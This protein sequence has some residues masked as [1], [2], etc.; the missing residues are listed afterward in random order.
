VTTL[1]P[2]R[3]RPVA[4]AAARQAG[5]PRTWLVLAGLYAAAVA[6]HSWQSLGH[7]TPAVFTDELLFAKLA[8]SF[9]AGDGFVLRGEAFFFPAPVAVVFQ[10][11]AWLLT[12]AQTAYEVAKALNAAV[13]TASVF[14][15]YWLAR[16]LTSRRASLLAAL[17]AVSAPGLLYHSYLMTDAAG[18]AAFSAALAVMTRAL[19]RPSRAWD[20]AVVGASLLAVLTRTQFVV[21]PLAYILA[22]GLVGRATGEGVRRSYRRHCL[23]CGALIAGGMLGALT[24]GVALGSYLGV[25]DLDYPLRDLIRW[26][27]LSAG[28]LPFSLGWL[29]APGALLGVG[30]LLIRPRTRAEAGFAALVGVITPLVVLESALIATGDAERVMER[31]LVYLVPVGFVAFLAYAERGAPGRLLHAGLA[32]ALGVVALLYPLA[33]ESEYRFSFDSPTLS[34][35]GE[36]NERLTDGDAAAIFAGAAVLGSLTVAMLALWRR[37][38]LGIAVAGICVLAVMGVAAYTADRSMTDR[39][40]AAFAAS[41]PDWLDQSGVGES[42]YLALPGA[43]AHAGWNLEAWNRDFGIP[44]RFAGA[45]PDHYRFPRARA[46]A[47][48]VLTVDGGHTPTTTLVVND[49]GSAAQFEGVVSLRPRPGLT[50]WRFAG[51]PRI[52]SL[53][54]GL[55]HDGWASA[56]VRYRVWSRPGGGAYHVRLALPAGRPRRNVVVAVQGGASRTVRL[57]G[58]ESTRITLPAGRSNAPPPLEIRTDLADF[59]GAGGPAPRLVAVRVSELSYAPFR[60]RAA[61]PI[62]QSREPCLRARTQSTPCSSGWSGAARPTFT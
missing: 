62:A 21:L 15:V 23:S 2:E 57:Q 49:Y 37:P 25:V 27:A 40:L 32:L 50:V 10:A 16:Q 38:G 48:G 22:V 56:L 13:M 46:N 36:L 42:D 60:K 6:Y 18:Y 3:P 17:A 24:G 33:T 55:Y 59:T 4:A 52:R 43:Q 5:G 20:A 47:R 61:L 41:P 51:P 53:A 14:P 11:A 29:I 31:Y 44:I 34:A 39:T 12:E 28:I 54:E 30:F 1:T 8:Q 9:A 19:G 7:R 58:G 26:S 45:E 35:Y